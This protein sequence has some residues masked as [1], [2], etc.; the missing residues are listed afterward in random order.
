MFREPLAESYTA[1]VYTGLAAR[2]AWPARN[3]LL[4]LGEEHVGLIK[5]LCSRIKL[6][7]ARVSIMTYDQQSK[8]LTGQASNDTF[9]RATYGA[10]LS[11]YVTRENSTFLPVQY[12]FCSEGKSNN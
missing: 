11:E 6:I 3:R 9:I 5:Q 12:L 7:I 8:T 10:L 1:T 4:L 2:A